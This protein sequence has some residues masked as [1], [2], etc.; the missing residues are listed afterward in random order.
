M[1]RNNTNNNL[2]SGALNSNLTIF[3]LGGLM[4]MGGNYISNMMS[5]RSTVTSNSVRLAALEE[6]MMGL[7]IELKD[8]Q[9]S[10]ITRDE[11]NLAINN[12]NRSVQDMRQEV[13]EAMR[14]NRQ[15]SVP[16]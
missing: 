14:Q 11:F 7:K 12:L 13:R 15:A 8:V 1:P 2:L 16:R 9:K 10:Y 4:L 3:I 5:D 6:K